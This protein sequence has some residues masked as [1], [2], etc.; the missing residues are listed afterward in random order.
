MAISLERPTRLA[1]VPISVLFLAFSLLSGCAG[2]GVSS[3]GANSP[4]PTGSVSVSLS[5]STGSV[6]TGATQSFM[7]TVQNDS[8]NKGVNWTLSGAGCSGTACGLLSAK[9]SVSG[10]AIVYTAPA[11]VPAPATVTVTAT[12]VADGTKSAAA[13]ITITG[14][15]KAI[16]VTVSPTSVSVPTGGSQNFA[17]TVQ[18]D[19]QNKGVNWALSGAG[20]SGAACG[21]L[22][23]SS[24]AAVTYTAPLTVPTAATVTLTATSVADGSKSATATI[25][26]TASAPAIVVSVSARNGC[27]F[28]FPQ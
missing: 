12:S 22:S 2:V 28:R 4:T 13:A 27:Q 9:S 25:T 11:T 26:V 19:S 18:N 16:V 23:A 24:S 5:P 7:A 17:A 14:A 10:A 3:K 8:Q 1:L 15:T 21:T 6:Q 20:C